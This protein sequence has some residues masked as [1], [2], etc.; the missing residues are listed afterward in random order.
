[1][2]RIGFLILCLGLL[3]MGLACSKRS[4]VIP[5]EIPVASVL[6]TPESVDIGPDYIAL[7]WTESTASSFT[8]YEVHELPALDAQPTASTLQAIVGGRTNTHYVVRG[9]VLN[10]SHVY[11]IRSVT[12]SGGSAVSNSIQVQTKSNEAPPPIPVTLLAPVDSSYDRVLLRWTANRER[13]FDRYV[14]YAST[15]SGF[16][17]TP[18][19]LVE[20]KSTFTDTSTVVQELRD[21]TTY[22]FKVAVYNFA[23]KV[24]SSNQIRCRTLPKG[25]ITPPQTPVVTV[26][27]VTNTSVQLSWTASP[28]TDWSSYRILTDTTD[29]FNPKDATKIVTDI[30]E[31]AS[32]SYTVT[33]LRPDKAHYFMVT[34][35][36]QSGNSSSS[37]YTFARTRPPVDPRYKF[38]GYGTAPGRFLSPEAAAFD[39]QGRLFVANTGNNRIE[40][41]LA[42]ATGDTSLVS[43][44]NV[45]G[46]GSAVS[47]RLPQGVAT[48]PAGNVYI[49]DTGNNRIVVISPDGTLLRTFGTFG[50]DSAGYNSPTALAV[51]DEGAV[52]ICD[53]GNDRIKKVDSLGRTLELLPKAGTVNRPSGVCFEPHSREIYVADQGHH[54]ILRFHLDG[55]RSTDFGNG[56]GSEVG[57]FN[58]PT[59]VTTDGLGRIY[60]ADTGNDRFQVF[61]AGSPSPL[62]VFGTIGLTNGNEDVLA[63]QLLLRK[64]RGMANSGSNGVIIDTDNTRAIVT[65]IT[66]VTAPERGRHLRP[67]VRPRVAARR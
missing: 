51:D 28:D 53:R 37:F 58:Q 27:A 4:D 63:G 3:L 15:V 43:G 17:P 64:P 47:L 33:G 39:A 35:F 1:M 20:V 61:L 24:S 52:W 57:Q 21:T 25:D 2:R 67:A 7:R 42:P 11:A 46:P 16:T 62:N 44:W 59:G 40:A 48:D 31:V 55:S 19:E 60:V 36:D 54:R 56:P 65:N 22:Y 34:S 49:A 29:T 8:S 66:F 18:A 10:T 30:R 32:T 5:P 14:V 9:L 13:T 12:R 6:Q 38:G 50:S 45:G 26:G 41:F 23:N